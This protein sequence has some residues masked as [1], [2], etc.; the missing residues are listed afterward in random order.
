MNEK[1]L[2]V[3]S[4]KY[5]VLQNDL[6]TVL[7]KGC[8]EKKIKIATAESCTGG[9]IS[10]KIT[11]VAGA[12]AVFDCGICSYSNEIKSTLLRVDKRTLKKHGAVSAQTALQMA[13]GVRELAEA[14][15]GISTTGIAGPDGGSAEKPVGL[16]YIGI[17][18][19]SGSFATRWSFNESRFNDRGAIRELAAKAALLLALEQIQ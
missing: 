6:P 19:V 17:S 16:V 5:S 10:K 4:A 3:I 15:I 7:V 1:D 12:S 11:D 2:T 18:T 14:D 8:L 13:A 9:L